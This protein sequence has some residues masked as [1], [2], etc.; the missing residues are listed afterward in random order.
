MCRP[1]KWT[2]CMQAFKEAEHECYTHAYKCQGDWWDGLCPRRRGCQIEMDEMSSMQYECVPAPVEPAEK[3]EEAGFGGSI[4]PHD[5]NRLLQFTIYTHHFDGHYS[6]DDQ[7]GR[8]MDIT[9]NFHKDGFVNFSEYETF[10][11]AMLVLFGDDTSP[12]DIDK[13][14]A[15]YGVDSTYPG[16]SKVITIESVPISDY[17]FKMIFLGEMRLQDSLYEWGKPME[18]DKQE[19]LDRLGIACA[20]LRDPH[21]Q[22]PEGMQVSMIESAREQGQS[23]AQ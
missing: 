4:T 15:T 1:K 6:A 23:L 10:M 12:P 17:W 5:I 16:R 20:C 9:D 8:H 11:K 13:I 18:F 3:K 19:V 7:S 14:F 22:S 21:A 2:R